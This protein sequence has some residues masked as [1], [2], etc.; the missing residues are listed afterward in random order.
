MALLVG[1]LSRNPL[2]IGTFTAWN[3]A[4]IHAQTRTIGSSQTWLFATFTLFCGL[5]F[6][7]QSQLGPFFVLK[8]VRSRGFGARFL[9]PF[10][11]SLVTVK[12]YSNTKMAV[13]NRKRPLIAV[14]GR[15]WRTR[16]YKK[17][18]Q[19]GPRNVCALS[20]SFALFCSHLCVS[21]SDRV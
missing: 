3:R 19:L 2:N 15:Y 11:K 16:W 21:A 12:Y 20:R 18:P 8:F 13:S 5:A 10:P 6:V 14:N 9:Q 17:R 1:F 7:T 4:R